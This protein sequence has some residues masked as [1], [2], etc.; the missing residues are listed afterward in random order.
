MSTKRRKSKLSPSSW[1]RLS[2]MRIRLESQPGFKELIEER[3]YRLRSLREERSKTDKQLTS[4]F[5]ALVASG[6]RGKI[7][8]TAENIVAMFS[9]GRILFF[10]L[11][12]FSIPFTSYNSAIVTKLLF[13]LW[14]ISFFSPRLGDAL[15]EWAELPHKEHHSEQR[16]LAY[17]EFNA[18]K[19]EIDE[20]WRNSCINFRGYPP[21]WEERRTEVIEDCSRTCVTCSSTHAPLHVHHIVPLSKGGSNDLS[22]LV[23]LCENCHE[24]AHASQD[25]DDD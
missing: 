10:Y 2:G 12:I 23:A 15:R 16:S 4:E 17:K 8:K 22:N 19:N 14:V 9:I 13:I 20:W 18:R 5:N 21:D 25:R 7:Y 1:S 24:D 6:Q 11:I 3:R